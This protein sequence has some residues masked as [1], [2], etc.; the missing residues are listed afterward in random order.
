VGNFSKNGSIHPYKPALAGY[1]SYG[2]VFSEMAGDFC[3]D[4]NGPEFKFEGIATTFI[5]PSPERSISIKDLY[6]HVFSD[7]N[8]IFI[9][10]GFDLDFSAYAAREAFLKKPAEPRK[11]APVQKET[12]VKDAASFPLDIYWS[13]QFK[14]GSGD[15]ARTV[16]VAEVLHN[17]RKKYQQNLVE[18]DRY[19]RELESI[20]K[21]ENVAKFLNA[22]SFRTGESVLDE[23]YRESYKKERF[24]ALL[25]RYAVQYGKAVSEREYKK[26][27]VPYVK[28]MLK[29]ATELTSM[30][31]EAVANNTR[32]A[33]MVIPLI[34][35]SVSLGANYV[36]GKLYV[37]GQKQEQAKRPSGRGS[38]SL[39]EFIGESVLKA[40]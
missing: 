6:S 38:R 33:E 4:F 36:S 22:V 10:N 39:Y 20:R 16:G 25:A 12:V 26:S 17:A 27:D 5:S 3:C 9:E 1:R 28:E 24:D 35:D 2:K 14:V 34:P 7:A 8:E 31:G 40:T 15:K 23:L 32:I 37:E 11:D 29:R 21:E 19:Q 30:M 13:A 18:I